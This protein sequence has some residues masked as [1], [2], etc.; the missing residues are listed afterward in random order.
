VRFEIFFLSTGRYIDCIIIDLCDECSHKSG[1]SNKQGV[2]SVFYHFCPS[3]SVSLT[4]C[5]F[6]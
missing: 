2:K 4:L 3:L 1:F 6:S 5:P